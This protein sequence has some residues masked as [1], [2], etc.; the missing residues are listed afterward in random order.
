MV[1][2]CSN[3]ETV[4]IWSADLEPIQ[5]L[6]GHSAFVFSAKAIKLGFYVSGGED[7]CLKIWEGDKCVQDIQQPGSIWSIAF[8][9]NNDLFVAQS[10]GMIRTFT[11]SESRKADPDV[12]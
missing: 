1:I 7:K 11:T 12:L 8:D 10:D 3:D 4:K 9:E 2:T 5:T 6:Q